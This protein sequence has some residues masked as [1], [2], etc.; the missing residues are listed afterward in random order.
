MCVCVCVCVDR[1]ERKRAREGLC[2]TV[3]F[4]NFFMPASASRLVLSSC[5]LSPP[6]SSWLA[7]L[8]CTGTC[9]WGKESFTKLTDMG[10]KA[11]FKT[12]AGMDHNFC[13]Q[14]LSDVASFLRDVLP[15][16]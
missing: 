9:R 8:L 16:K 11:D 1:A 15:P 3:H 12:Y 10:A 14:E 6:S 4:P 7:S 2:V 5:M 13:P